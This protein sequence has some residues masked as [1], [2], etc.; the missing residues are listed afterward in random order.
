[1]QKR[2]VSFALSLCLLFG[3]A[4]AGFAAGLGSITYESGLK[5]AEGAVVKTV[6]AEHTAGRE[7][8]F[9]FEYTP[10]TSVVPQVVYGNKLYGRSTILQTGSFA[11]KQG[12]S[13]LG[14]INGDFFTLA[15][16]LP[17]GIVIV[18]GVLASSDS[19]RTA[20]GFFDDGTAMIGRPQINTTLTGAAGSIN[21]GYINKLRTNLG[22]YLYTEDYS[23]DT[24]TSGAGTDIV[25]RKQT[26]D[27][28]RLGESMELV[29]ESIGTTGKAVTIAPGTMVL[30]LDAKA[31]MTMPAFAVGDV[32]TLRTA[33]TDTRWHSVS[34]AVGADVML[35]ENGAIA[36][37]LSTTREPRTAFGLK[38]DGSMVF[39]TVDGRQSGY[40]VGLSLKDLAEE[41]HARGCV[42]AVNLDGGGS[43][44]AAVRYPGKTDFEIISSPSDG[45]PRP[46]ANYIYFLNKAPATGVASKLY[47]YPYETLALPG[48]RVPLSVAAVDS[49]Y[50][51]VASLPSVSYEA[52]GGSME[53]ADF[54]AGLEPGAAEVRV[55]ASGLE[56]AVSK[57]TI[58][59]KIEAIKVTRDGKALSLL[60]LEPAQT[61]KLSA[62]AFVGNRRVYGDMSNLTFSVSNGV[63]SIS[64]DGTFTATA[65]NGV[66]G[67]ITVSMGETTASISVTV[68]KL[69][70]TLEGFEGEGALFAPSGA[71]A[72]SLEGN[73]AYVRYGFSSMRIDYDLAKDKTDLVT[74]TPAAAYAA[75]G[76]GF[77]TLWVYGD[78]SGLIVSTDFS[79]DLAAPNLSANQHTIDF[80]GW[81]ALSFALPDGAGSLCSLK[82][83]APS[84]GYPKGTIWIDQIAT[85]FSEAADVTPPKISISPA[86]GGAAA[87][88]GS[89][90]DTFAVPKAGITATLDGKPIAFAYSEGGG[91]FAAAAESTLTPGIHRLSVTACDIAGNLSRASVDFTGE[92]EIPALFADMSGHWAEG[93]VGFLN[94]R[95]VLTGSDTPEGMV[96]KPENNV[97]RL[98]M[99]AII[100]R[101]LGLNPDNYANVELPYADL[102]SID[103]WGI[104]YVKALYAEG[105]MMGRQ[106]GNR[107]VFAPR[108]GITRE[109]AVTTLGR[110]GEM[111][112]SLAPAGF[113][114]EKNI[115]SYAVGY[116]NM[117]AANGVLSGYSDGT[118]RPKN[119]IKRSEIAAIIYKLY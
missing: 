85:A 115:S 99:A 47:V 82:L 92:G 45:S 38:A 81:R 113:A 100:A 50:H 90:T 70:S 23:A 71:A 101:Y 76:A 51:A 61:A 37:G 109:E 86:E 74:L 80:T 44:A 60:A 83:T 33:C 69:P 43:T 25:L 68:G 8:A 87:V 39:I 55:N 110:T 4:A 118:I 106:D 52:D 58:V 5:L 63:G 20:I 65:T 116:M 24:K 98:E 78:N 84:G 11:E 2:I 7:Q 41:L 16:G 105:I 29:V 77:I 72:V 93:Y 102:S 103:A 19:W 22:F 21:V 6:E 94:E 40:S 95:S 79:S 12:E 32:L 64:Q 119:N 89:I 49:G 35:I 36:S 27:A 1:M 10:N 88:S 62:S 66:S 114:D 117:F 57:I 107:L 59:E 53:G 67:V 31:S 111:G 73:N 56:G 112:Y 96:F 28:L 18:D 104:G 9:I 42:T 15:N 17:S 75:N 97:T 48:A 91:Q 34:S 13:L 54:V 14:G 108:A 30:S 26:G 3:L 46:G